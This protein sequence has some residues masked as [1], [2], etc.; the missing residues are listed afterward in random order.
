MKAWKFMAR[1]MGRCAS[2]MVGTRS[3]MVKTVKTPTGWADETTTGP[4]LPQKMTISY[5]K[6]STATEM[7]Y[8]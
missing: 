8:N 4:K 5:G 6:W 7:M 2:K 3:A 1:T